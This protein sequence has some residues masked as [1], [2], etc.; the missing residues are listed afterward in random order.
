[1]T[2]DQ[3]AKLHQADALLSSVVVHLDNLQDTRE[4]YQLHYAR[5]AIMRALADKRDPFGYITVSEASA[6]LKIP[7][8]KVKRLLE[9]RQI[10]GR[11]F[12]REW[13]VMACELLPQPGIDYVPNI[14]DL[15][16]F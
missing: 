1:M 5:I 9:Q 14:D 6:F 4:L 15:K 3:I 13:R 10:R 16:R 8:S 7:E 12:G 11:R 2:Q